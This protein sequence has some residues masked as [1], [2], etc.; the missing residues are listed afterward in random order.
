MKDNCELIEIQ[1]RLRENSSEQVAASI[2]KFVPGSIKV[3]GNKIPFL[4]ELA[5]EFKEAGFDLVEELW[6]TGAFEE[7]MLAVK[8]LGKMAKKDPERSMN[9][10]KHFAPGIDNWAIC[11]AMGMQGLKP[12]LKSRQPIIFELANYYN[13]SN[14]FGERRLS[15]VLVE[16]YTR[17]KNMH[18]Q[19]IPLINALET[20]S[21]YYVK[22]SGRMVKK[23]S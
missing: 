10:I 16:W 14:N 11:D 8:M 7:K 12:M 5:K 19:V 23:K 21:E 20:D 18:H 22:K 15:L 2:R 4:N 9:L 1:K 6:N 17:D 3:Y 13:S